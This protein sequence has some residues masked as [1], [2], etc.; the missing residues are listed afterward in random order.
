MTNFGEISR[1]VA[2]LLFNSKGELFLQLRSKEK[3]V[4]PNTWT[5]SAS[6]KVDHNESYEQAAKRELKEELDI[7]ASVEPIFTLLTEVPPLDHK[8]A[9]GAWQI[10]KATHDG[11]INIKDD[12]IQDGKFFPIA[13]LKDMMETIPEKFSPAFAKIF[14]KYIETIEETNS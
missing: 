2:I 4:Y 10:F 3:R 14:K 7:E 5:A 13:R 9:P 1:L 12:E 11:A 6:G 8:P